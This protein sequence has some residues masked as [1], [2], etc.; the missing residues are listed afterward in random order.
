MLDVNKLN[1]KYGDYTGKQIL[2][3]CDHKILKQDSVW[4]DVKKICQD[5]HA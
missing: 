4:T 3:F 1:Q 2:S 5:L